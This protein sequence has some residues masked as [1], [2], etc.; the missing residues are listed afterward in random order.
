MDIY[1]DTTTHDMAVQ[2]SDIRFTA[3]DEDIVQRLKIRLQF[4]L[5][6]WFLNTSLGIPYTQTIFENG[7][8][9]LDTVYLI[10]E[11]EIKNTEGVETIDSLTITPDRGSRLATVSL[12]VNR[13][14]EVEVT[15]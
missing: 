8:N 7:I 12:I 4:L 13:D 10:F 6:E 3:E 11:T 2:D 15:I 9:D 5:G 14:T 1:F